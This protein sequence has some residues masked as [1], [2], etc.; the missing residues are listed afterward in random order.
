MA[1]KELLGHE[2][3]EMTSGTGHLSPDVKR[4]AVKLLDL[5]GRIPSGTLTATQPIA[6]STK[7]ETPDN[8]V[9]Y[10]GGYMEREK[11]FEHLRRVN[12]DH[13]TAHA[14]LSF[15]PSLP[16]VESSIRFPRLPH[17]SPGFSQRPGD[18]RETGVAP[19]TVR[20]MLPD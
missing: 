18:I 12:S 15:H 14:F 1:V 3:I 19:H 6:G 11:G 8:S 10:R 16:L 7:E 20:R 4:D 13:A 2:R 17:P 5:P 9:S